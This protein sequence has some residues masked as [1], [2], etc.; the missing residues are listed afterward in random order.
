[1]FQW[2]IAFIGWQDYKQWT[3]WWVNVQREYEPSPFVIAPLHVRNNRVNA[4]ML[5]EHREL[6]LKTANTMVLTIFLSEWI[7]RASAKE[8]NYNRFNWFLYYIDNAYL[9][10]F[11]MNAKKISL[12]FILQRIVCLAGFMNYLFL[13]MSIICSVFTWRSD[14]LAS[15]YHVLQRCVWLFGT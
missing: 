2:G 3:I 13:Q 6:E 1:M 15:W 10:E 4:R 12:L 9:T 8:R 5:D 14:A 7:G 11:I